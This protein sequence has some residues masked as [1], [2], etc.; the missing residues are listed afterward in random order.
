M[1]SVIKITPI[2]KDECGPPPRVTKLGAMQFNQIS[3]TQFVL[4][5]LISSMEYNVRRQIRNG[6]LGFKPQPCDDCIAED[7]ELS[8]THDHRQC[9]RY[10]PDNNK[11]PTTSQWDMFVAPDDAYDEATKDEASYEWRKKVIVEEAT[12]IVNV[13]DFNCDQRP[14]GE[15]SLTEIYGFSQS[16]MVSSI[17]TYH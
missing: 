10:L 3:P 2:H 9:G 7:M 4:Q 1:A 11:P 12:A 13:G 5:T 16:H 17:I 15:E 8:P 14:L 6:L